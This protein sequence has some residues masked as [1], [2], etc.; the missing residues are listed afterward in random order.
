MS[1]SLK[2]YV[3]YKEAK[4]TW[5]EQ[6]PVHWKEVKAKRLFLETSL[7][8]YPEE[9]LLS[10]TQSH[11]VIPRSMVKHRVVMP[12]GNL[13]TFKLVKEGNFVISL[14]SFQ[15]GLEYSRY[16]GIVSPAY[17]IL[18]ERMNQN[19]EYFKYLFK[20]HNFIGELQRNV[21]G[22]RQ[23]KNIDVNDFKETVLPIPPLKEQE[24]IVQYL[25]WKV[26]KI[27]KFI[28]A[29]KDLISVL[30]EQKQAVV[31]E[32]VTKGLNPH[33]KMK[34]SGISWLGDIPEHWE[35]RPLRQLLRPVSIKNRP[36]LPLLSV[37]REKGVILR[38]SMSKE[39]NHN[40]IPDD[41]SGYKMVKAGQFAMNKMKAWQG[42]YGVSPYH[43][44]VSPAYYIFDLNFGNKDYFH[45]AIRSKVYVNFFYQASDGIRVGQWDLSLAKMKE[46]PFFIPPEAE[47]K[48]ILKYIPREFKRIEDSVE[49]LQKEIELIEEYRIRLIADVVTGKLDIQNIEMDNFLIEEPDKDINDDLLESKEV[50]EDEE[51][52]I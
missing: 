38:S 26:T 13:E 22:I 44:I 36:D 49:R 39:E 15:G 14:R 24:K 2:P 31:N 12:S 50:L 18:E 35:I 41:L 7:K 51:C 3:E 5:L 19:R 16:R 33:M 46:I 11:G 48:E 34:S 20:S 8:N 27:K 40:Y 32:A 45:Y 17:T 9:E 21:T 42:S 52:E 43:G 1:S 37:V 6:I 47:Q 28:K 23:G 25:D 10:A 4:Q 30:K 29:K